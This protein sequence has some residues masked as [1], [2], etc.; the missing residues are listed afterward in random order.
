MTD[1]K[2]AGEPETRHTR[3]GQQ[4]ALGTTEC[5]CGMPHAEARL[6]AHPRDAEAENARQQEKLEKERGHGRYDDRNSVFG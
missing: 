6:G 5:R 2:G 4:R 3:G 1:G